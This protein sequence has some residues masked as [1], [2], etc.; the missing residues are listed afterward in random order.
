MFELFVF[1]SLAVIA[2]GPVLVNSICS[3][4]SSDLDF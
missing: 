3:V 4:R 1:L 2:L